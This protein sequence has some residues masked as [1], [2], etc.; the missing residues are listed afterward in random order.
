MRRQSSIRRSWVLP[1]GFTAAVL[2]SARSMAADRLPILFDSTTLPAPG[3]TQRPWEIA[4]IVEVRRITGTAISG[5]TGKAAFVVKQSFIDA[6]DIRYGLYVADA[7]SRTARKIAEAAYIDDLSWHPG[8]SLWTV[9][10]DFGSGIQ[11][12]DIDM[13]GQEYPLVVNSRTVVVGAAESVID[14][15][16]AEGPRATGVASYEWAP[17]GRSLWYSVYRLRDASQRAAIMQQ[18]IVYDDRTMYLHS[19]FNDP[20]LVL[21]VELHVLRPEDS[22]DRSL[23]FIPSG[24]GAGILFSHEHGSAFWDKDSRHIYYSSWLPK[25]DASWDY[26][27]WTMDVDSGIASELSGNTHAPYLLFESVPAPDRAG[28]LT[29]RLIGDTHRLV[30]LANDGTT[31]QDYGVVGFKRVSSHYGFGAWFNHQKRS[32]ILAVDY[33]DRQSLVLIPALGRGR[34]LALN[35]DAGSLS[36]CSFSSDVRYGI[37]ARERQNTVPELVEVSMQTGMVKTAIRVNPAYSA[38]EP[39]HIE[40]AEWVNRYG[41]RNDGYISYPRG[42]IPGRTYPTILVTHGH[43]ARDDFAF[44]GFQWEFPIQAWA[45]GGY[46]VLSVNEPRVNSRI[47]AALDAR[48]GIDAKQ[49]VSEVQF[50]EAFNAI[51]SIE[52][53]LTS[54]VAAGLADPEK[55]G[56]AGYSRGAEIVEWSMTQSKLFH[57]AVEGDAGGFLAGHYGSV[58]SWARK[59]YRQ[60]YGGSPFDPDVLENYQ[61]LS[62]SFRTKRFSGPLLQ[63]FTKTNGP[64]GMELHSLLRDQGIP[65]ELVFFP[66]ENHVFW[67]PR[68]RAAAMQRSTDWFDYW[69]LGKR[70][71]E[72]GKQDQYARWDAMAAIWEKKVQ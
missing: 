42:Y 15:N 34:G 52:A 54:E 69:L 9:R 24:S 12:Y 61:R 30:E 36:H 5:K 11:L 3:M 49:S 64:A 28:F 57:V 33:D 23:A 44:D 62:P 4:D 32:L 50:N 7:H 8:T 26:S 68:H 18:G 56:I 58:N 71:P 1:I 14:A 48:M 39:L 60:L 29:V 10:A 22:T 46:L 67:D 63:L 19:F 66:I 20:T 6:D 72:A 2:M 55:T 59:Y 31:L 37:C 41:N 40:H 25:P 35:G 21:G 43:D 53:A 65:T 17:N 13:R 16:A 38:I 47:L 27:N 70:R 51:S 45:A